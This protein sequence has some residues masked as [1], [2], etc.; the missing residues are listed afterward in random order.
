MPYIKDVDIQSGD[1]SIQPLT[2][3]S[4]SS[5]LG[6]DDRVNTFKVK[7]I[8]NIEFSETEI[9]LGLSYSARVVLYEI[10]ETMDVYS[11]F[12]NNHR[13]YLQR[14]SRGDRDDFIGFS[15]PE[16]V[17]AQQ[18][19]ITISHLLPVRASNEPD[20]T[21]ELKALVVCVPETATAMRWSSTK[22][23]RITVS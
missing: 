11:I 6:I 23:V 5:D 22:K 10:D 17:K 9:R 3:G 18:G 21:M 8:A 20:R 15:N 2:A 14:A 7:V 12:P 16:T 4:S 13:L 1:S 19:G